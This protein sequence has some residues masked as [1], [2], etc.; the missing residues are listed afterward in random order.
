M[1]SPTP[2]ETPD[3]VQGHS[4]LAGRTVVVTAAAGAGIGAAA[5]KR[6]LEED[7]KA[8]IIGD[9]HERR[10][11]A[12]ATSLSE[13]FGSDRVASVLSD[14]S[15]EE[16]VQALLDAA[17]PFGGVDVLINN[18]GLGGHASILDMT[19]D[20]WSRVIDVSLTGAFRVNR[21]TL[22]RMVDQG[23]K[24]A[25]VNNSSILAHRTLSGQAHYGA[26]K[27]GLNALTRAAALDV[28]EYGIRVNA[29][30]PSLVVHPFLVKASSEEVIEAQR[31][32][33]A[34]KRSAEA[35]EVANVMVFL[36]SDYASYITGEVVPVSYRHP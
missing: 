34:F 16:Q 29:V 14:V 3:Y 8:V 13:E 31:Q 4:L 33:E 2:V 19:D 7:A 10:L 30:A 18:A 21:A 24:G 9:I 27:A 23:K 32:R 36:A 26:A 5:A 20:E 15:S 22:R 17:E 1:T 11:D 12:V 6:C 25:I 35:W 28:A